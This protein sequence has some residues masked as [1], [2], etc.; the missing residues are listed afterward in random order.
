MNNPFDFDE[1]IA[2]FENAWATGQAPDIDR[3]LLSYAVMD[4]TA[5]LRLLVELV[6]IDIEHR[7]RF[8]E[9]PSSQS[10]ERPVE[11]YLREFPEL[12]KL[13]AAIE[14]LI[15]E[16]LRGQWRRGRCPQ[17][18]SYLARFP[19]RDESVLAA[20]RRVVQE[21]S[22]EVV[23]QPTASVQRRN[24]R[25]RLTD[26]LRQTGLLAVSE[27]DIVLQRLIG[28]GGTGK[29]YRAWQKSENRAV[30]IKHLRKSFLDDHETVARFLNEATTVGMLC[31]DNIVRVRGLGAT[32]G[33]SCFI[34]MDLVDGQ[35]LAQC[36][37]QGPLSVELAVQYILQACLAI[38][39]AHASGVLHCDL[40]PANLLLDSA[41]TVRLTDFGFARRIGDSTGLDC[42]IA[43]TA[44]FMA[45]EQVSD[46]W[47]NVSARTDVYGLGA[48]LYSLLTARA[49]WC[50][51]S[52][53]DVL[54]QIACNQPPP[55]P[56]LFN[57]ELTNNV[58]QVCLR[59]LSKRSELRF[60]T[61]AE[62]AI[63]LASS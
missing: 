24:N 51:N 40:K 31:H 15:A 8:R 27:G 53:P 56:Q 29:V 20:I 48:V 4:E 6:A 12:A 39:C 14:D 33:G 3:Y 45:P 11:D 30:A 44:P 50:G 63:A 57:P 23:E 37:R 35:D 60:A 41:G 43:G 17:I 19:G 32:R 10:P 28:V 13:P 58:C 62:F 54:S 5:R 22:D 34:V 46:A 47:G 25:A 36:I 49:P 7:A 9:D 59:C 1:R 18:E 52:I 55:S 26:S 16:E 42:R 2:A 61:A 38:S 21:S